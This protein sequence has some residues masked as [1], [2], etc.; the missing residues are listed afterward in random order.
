MKASLCNFCNYFLF[1][2][3]NSKINIIEQYVEE[4][5]PWFSILKVYSME[6]FVTYFGPVLVADYN[7]RNNNIINMRLVQLW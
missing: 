5:T 1:F 6:M 2:P 4:Y 7:H 3:T